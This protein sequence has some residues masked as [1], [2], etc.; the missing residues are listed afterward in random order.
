[1]TTSSE[2]NNSLNYAK[3]LE[4]LRTE[5]ASV[6]SKVD[7]ASKYQI[8]GHLTPEL[9]FS[10]ADA[11]VTTDGLLLDAMKERVLGEGGL[12]EVLTNLKEPTA[13]EGE[14]Q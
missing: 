8:D 4:G 10:D 12:V 3:V 6:V 2:I 14:M 9:L 7:S 11:V 1:M 13:N 5:L